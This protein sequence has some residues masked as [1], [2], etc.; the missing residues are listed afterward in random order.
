MIGCFN[1][2]FSKPDPRRFAAKSLPDGWNPPPV[3]KGKERGKSS[4]FLMDEVTNTFGFSDKP[5]ERAFEEIPEGLT[6]A[7]VRELQ[8]QNLDPYNPGYAAAKAV[9]A[10]NPNVTKKELHAAVPT[11]ARETFKDVLAAFRA[12]ARSPIG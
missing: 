2:I 9:F 6:P 3:T 7:D 4:V 8:K 5:F 12:A 1:S 10:R 11:V